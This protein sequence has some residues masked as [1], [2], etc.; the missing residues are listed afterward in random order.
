MQL[1]WG[2]MTGRELAIERIQGVQ[3]WYV[4]THEILLFSNFKFMT[5]ASVCCWSK[6]CLWALVIVEQSNRLAC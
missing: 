1:G 6:V 2:L 4:N 5:D 3:V